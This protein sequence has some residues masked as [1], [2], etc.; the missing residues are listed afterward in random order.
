MD[1]RRPHRA[2]P[3]EFPFFDLEP[4]YN[5]AVETR[6]SRG[7]F[8]T[9]D[10]M[11]WLKMRVALID[12]LTPT[13]LE[14]V[15]VAAD[16][17]NGVSQRLDTRRYSFINPDLTVA[18]HRHP[19]GEWVGLAARTDFDARG[20][21]LADSRIYDERGPVGRGLQTLVIRTRD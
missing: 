20:I 17:G 16:S 8:G 15:M 4:S 11:A 2:T 5:Q 7:A 1:E 13:P 6:F 9:G 10:V 18:L 14:R 19:I 12:G 3:A 21:G